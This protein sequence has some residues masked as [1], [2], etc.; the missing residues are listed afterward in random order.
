MLKPGTWFPR[1]Y[2]TEE[3]CKQPSV[4]TIL[5]LIGGGEA[6]NI[7]AARCCAE[8]IQELLDA[9][10]EITPEQLEKARLHF[11]E[12]SKY[13]CDVGSCVHRAIE[14]FLITGS[15][16]ED[17]GE[18]EMSSLLAWMQWYEDHKIVPIAIEQPLH[19]PGYSGCPDYIGYIDGIIALADW[20]TS[21]HHNIAY[22]MQA[23]A[24]RHAWNL[25]NPDMKVEKSYVIILSKESGKPSVKDVT[26]DHDK[27]LEAFLHLTSIWKIIR[28]ES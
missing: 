24:Y 23:A 7:W 21:K 12:V 2:E 3:G 1:F 13:A 14:H 10:E 17:P 27:H 9:G 5:S 28:G 8:N 20:K 15:F 16:P 4:T 19:G 26:K 22:S 11:R 18:E 6:L 25:N